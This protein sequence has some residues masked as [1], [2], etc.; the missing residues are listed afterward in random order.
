LLVVEH[1]EDTMYSADHI[2]D[3]GPLA[4]VRGGNVVAQGTVEDI[5]A[6]AE[7][8]TGQYLSGKKSI[9]VPE[10]RRQSDGK[11]IEV[12]GATE[13]NLKNITVR[14]PLGLFTAI[15]GVSGSGKSTL[16]NEI[17]YKGLAQKVYGSRAKPGSHKTPAGRGLYR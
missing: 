12:V 5:K 15:T 9:P 13:N 1:D 7:S 6:C 16:I 3:I 17:L 8:I 14:F 11:W 2:I 4:G 10:Q